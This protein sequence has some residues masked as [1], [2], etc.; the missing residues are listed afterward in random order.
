MAGIATGTA[1]LV[2]VLSVFNGFSNLIADLYNAF[3]PDIKIVPREGKVFD[4]AQ[5][6]ADSLK[7]LPG[8]AAV[9]YVLEENALVRYRD[10]QTVA[11]IKGVDT[12]FAHTSQIGDYMAEGTFAMGPADPP[13]AVVGSG[14]AYA[15]G[16]N[17]DD[18]F[19]TLGMYV[20]K[21]GK[22]HAFVAEQAF[23]NLVIRPGGVFVIQQDFD[24]RYILVPLAFA[25]DLTGEGAGV[26]ALEVAV[27]P[28]ADVEAVREGIAGL[29]GDAFRV[30][31]RREQHDFL[32]RIFQSE[33][34]AIYLILGFIL[35][36]AS[37]SIVGS[38]NM[39]VI[40][41]RQ[42]IATLLAMGC[43]LTA[44]RRI[45]LIQGTLISMAG[46]LAGIALG[47]L[48]GYV[49]L[50][51]KPVKIHNSEAFLI[52][53]YPVALQADDFVNSFLIVFGT[54]LL[55]SWFTTGRTV[56]RERILPAKA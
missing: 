35:L 13:E 12:A 45:F 21:K 38:V 37:F 30:L 36:I 25:R 47:G 19:S 43:P 28:G 8:V 55:L 17:L 4:P 10:R 26:T 40:E 54:G 22:G 6:H 15:L 24:S 39:L 18:L 44:V 41:K 27:T 53:A 52:D 32:N 11:T 56:R 51:F 5:V 50:V 34:W 9:S 33:K 42:D 3:D 20:P 46:G 29:A 49:Q 1:G 48:I 16:M 23:T 2:I 14:L 31:D 7:S